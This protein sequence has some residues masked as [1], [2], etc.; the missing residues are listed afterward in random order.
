MKSTIN[1]VEESLP[2]EV[3]QKDFKISEEEV[4]SHATIKLTV[5]NVLYLI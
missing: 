4:K 2:I 5:I 1:A 3:L